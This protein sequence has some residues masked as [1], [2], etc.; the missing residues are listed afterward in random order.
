MNYATFWQRFAAGWIDFF[1]LLPLILAHSWLESIS[2][3]AALLLVIPMASAYAAYTIY[4]HA[5]FG[6]TVGKHAMGIRVVRVSG[7]RIGWREAWLRSSVDVAFAALEAIASYVALT[8]I[9][10][11]DYYRGWMQR[12]ESLRALEPDWLAWTSAASQVWVWSEV[13]V[14]LSNKRRRALHDFIAGT[15]VAREQKSETPQHANQ[16]RVRAGDAGAI[17]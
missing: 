17:D 13:V 8:S 12:G 15:V 1:V 10:D 3:L 2:R 6:Q 11:V 4:C 14:M 9:A 16:Q 7:E 5:R